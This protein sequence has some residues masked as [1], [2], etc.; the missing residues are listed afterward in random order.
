MV[1]KYYSATF[2][3]KT[4]RFTVRMLPFCITKTA[5]LALKIHVFA[6]FLHEESKRM[7]NVLLLQCILFNIRYML[8]FQIEKIF[9]PDF[10]LFHANI[11]T[12][13]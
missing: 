9:C 8:I 3:S 1:K 4:D 13:V 7:L 12:T 11:L 10:L 5:V 2:H 6:S